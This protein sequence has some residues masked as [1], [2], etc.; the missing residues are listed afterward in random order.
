MMT[1]MTRRRPCRC[2]H[3]CTS[4]QI[5]RDLKAPPLSGWSENVERTQ[6]GAKEG[7]VERTQPDDEK[8]SGEMVTC[9]IC[10]L[11]VSRDDV[12]STLACRACHKS[13]S[14]EECVSGSAMNRLRV[15]AGLP[16][17]EDDL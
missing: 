6:P 7:N 11:R 14:F 10:G 12:C 17:M 16:P 9:S 8:G 15:R 5:G 13:I 1:R 2:C 3:C 4:P